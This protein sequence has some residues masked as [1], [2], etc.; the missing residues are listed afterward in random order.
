MLY[1]QYGSYKVAFSDTT[2]RTNITLSGAYDSDNQAVIV[3][4]TSADATQYQVCMNTYSN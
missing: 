1:Q 2:V 3:N 4:V